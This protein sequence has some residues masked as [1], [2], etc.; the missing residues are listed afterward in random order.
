M[1]ALSKESVVSSTA[2]MTTVRST[3]KPPN[4]YA[5]ANTREAATAGKINTFID[6]GNRIMWFCLAHKACYARRRKLILEIFRESEMR[7]RE[8]ERLITVTGKNLMGGNASILL[9]PIKMPG[10]NMRFVD[11]SSSSDLVRVNPSTLRLG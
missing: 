5:A 9:R 4:T 11:D 10:W 1:T 3:A 7:T 8:L 6:A 2:S